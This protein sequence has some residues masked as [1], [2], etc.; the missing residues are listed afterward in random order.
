MQEKSTQYISIVWDELLKK[1]VFTRSAEGTEQIGAVVG[2]G[3]DVGVG[4]EVGVGLAVT[5]VLEVGV[6]VIV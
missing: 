1:V 5:V 6:A 3:V 2:V 4:D